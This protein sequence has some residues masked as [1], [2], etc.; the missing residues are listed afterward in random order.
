MHC[1]SCPQII[2]LVRLDKGNAF[3]PKKEIWKWFEGKRDELFLADVG[4]EVQLGVQP[5]S[6]SESIPLVKSKVV[7][8]DAV[9]RIL[10]VSPG[11]QLA[12]IERPDAIAVKRYE[13][14]VR[15]GHAASL[16]DDESPVAVV[17]TLTRNAEPEELLADLGEASKGVTLHHDP[18]AYLSGKT[19]FE[20]WAARQQLG[21]AEPSGDDV[22]RS[23]AEERLNG[24]LPDGSWD[25]NLVVTTRRLRELSELGMD[26]SDA[27]VA[28]GAEWLLTRPESP[29]NP[30][31]FFL[32]DALV[33]KQMAVVADRQQGRG[34]R[35][36]DRKK[37]EIARARLGDD[38]AP[39]PCAPRLMWPN[40][41]AIEALIALGLEA[42]PRAQ[43][44]LD[45]LE[46]AGWCEC[47]YQHGVN[48]LVQQ[49]PLTEERLLTLEEEFL[50]RFRNGG[51]ERA[52]DYN[53]VESRRVTALVTG[54]T[55][56]YSV[57]LPRHFQPCE[58]ITVKALHRTLRPR[59]RRLCEAYLWHFVA[60][61]HGPG[62]RFAG[63]SR[64]MG[65]FFYLDL[66]ARY[67]HPAAKIAILRSLPW[68]VEEQ[69]ADGSWGEGD[70][71]DAATRVVLAALQ[72]VSLISRAQC[73]E[74]AGPSD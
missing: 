62:G 71:K 37:R 42:H 13:Q 59:L 34:G 2:Q 72:C 20:A 17:R 51:A 6:G 25:G 10:A 40:A 63:N 50:E 69:N 52:E 35:F 67:D 23:L 53:S 56:T 28:R 58:M 60:R 33:E 12:L 44:A 49:H 16:I 24:Q 68:L 7:L 66:F 38:H 55:T 3:R 15:T 1:T 18:L 65:A 61:Q 5:V 39:D 22:R 45:S 64:H 14:V 46:P 26:R 9:C 48:G 43:R 31:M 70:G 47:S 74:L 8:P 19:S 57:G 73:P 27:C 41:Y 11:D 4:G 29:H 30:G 36:R 32:T 54:S 21:A